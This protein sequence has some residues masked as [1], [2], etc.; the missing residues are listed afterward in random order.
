M[1]KEIASF[2]E[3][4]DEVRVRSA[5]ERALQSGLDPLQ[6]VNDGLI[7]GMNVV[8]LKFREGDMFVPEVLM[9]AACMAA[10][11][12]IVKPHLQGK[13]IPTIATAIVG[14]VEGDLHDIGKNLVVMLLQI[15]GFKVIDLGINVTPAQFVKAAQENSA[16]L[17]GMSA[18]L[19]T[20]M[21]KM[22]DTIETFQE[23][24]LRD[25]VKFLVGGAPVSQDFADQIGA[26]GYAPDAATAAELAKSLCQ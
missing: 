1:L 7:A 20:T 23:D 4:C 10:G 17:V 2:V 26:D 6:V 22:K 16:K 8:G 11:M 13:E 15:A 14:T 3:D 12:E 5:V 21:M 9:A 24:G 19:T 18:L 25:S